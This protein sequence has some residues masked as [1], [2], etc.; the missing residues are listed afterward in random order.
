MKVKRG[1]ELVIETGPER[2]RDEGKKLM[3]LR[4]S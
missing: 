2:G 1:G 4:S 3:S